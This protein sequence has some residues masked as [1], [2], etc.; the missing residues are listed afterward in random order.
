MCEYCEPSKHGICTPMAVNDIGFKVPL[1]DL[2]FDNEKRN[3]RI[4][5]L[6]HYDESEPIKLNINYCPMCG[7]NL[8]EA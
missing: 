7:R 1:V 2:W 6:V 3:N 5:M 8:K 4:I